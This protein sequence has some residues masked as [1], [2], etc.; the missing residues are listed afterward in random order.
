[1]T[2]PL[3]ACGTLEPCT[4]PVCP[5]SGG[6]PPSAAL[7]PLLP[8]PPTHSNAFAHGEKASSF[9]GHSGWAL[10]GGETADLAVFF[11]RWTLS[12]TAATIVSGAVAER[13]SFYAYLG[14][15]LWLSSFVYPVVAHGV[16]A[17]FSCFISLLYDSCRRP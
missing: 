16:R 12:A 6:A 1:M 11:F 3:V 2:D 9:I 4:S 13:A 17:R 10:A 5:S 8:S 15:T 14:A 7:S